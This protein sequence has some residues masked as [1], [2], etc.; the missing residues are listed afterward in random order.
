[1]LKRLFILFRFFLMIFFRFLINWNFPLSLEKC[2]F[3]TFFAIITDQVLDRG[4]LFHMDQSVFLKKAFLV[5][6][7]LELLRAIIH[8]RTW[9]PKL[10]IGTLNIDKWICQRTS[11]VKLELDYIVN[12]SKANHCFWF[13]LSCA[14]HLNASYIWVLFPQFKNILRWEGPMIELRVYKN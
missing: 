6:L 10:E 1:M 4:D 3:F 8:K 11:Q 13:A 9:I 5:D 14:L 7:L 12:W 2:A